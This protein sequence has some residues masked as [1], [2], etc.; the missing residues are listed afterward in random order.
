MFSSIGLLNGVSVWSEPASTPFSPVGYIQLMARPAF[1]I[2]YVY[3]IDM[4]SVICLI[5]ISGL[6]HCGVRYS[7]VQLGAQIG[8][9]Y[10]N[11]NRAQR[12]VHTGI[13]VRYY[14]DRHWTCISIWL[15]TSACRPG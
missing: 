14:L 12:M 4:F 7:A 5:I 9:T 3:S 13:G 6:F 2:E 10:Y 1:Q 8:S 15:K 11:T